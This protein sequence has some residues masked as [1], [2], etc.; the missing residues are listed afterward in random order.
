[1]LAL[2]KI[3][4]IIRGVGL[5]LA[6]ILIFALAL[7]LYFMF[8]DLSSG[9]F[10][11]VILENKINCSYSDHVG[12]LFIPIRV[13]YNGSRTIQNLQVVA[14]LNISGNVMEYETLPVTLIGSSY[15]IVMLKLTLDNKTA[16][17][18]LK[19]NVTMQMGIKFLYD[20]IFSI[21]T[22]FEFEG[23]KFRPE[24]YLKYEISETPAP[25][26]KYV[27]FGGIV[28][29]PLPIPL[30]GNITIVIHNGEVHVLKEIHVRLKPCSPN[31]VATNFTFKSK[32]LERGLTYTVF[33]NTEEGI[34][35]K[36]GKGS[37]RG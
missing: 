34:S 33:F 16:L 23:L 37:I 13:Y 2:R 12:T 17:K 21:K 26:Y 6:L 9:N 4:D 14:A 10:G 22:F 19:E 25:E 35:I 24:A 36:L 15:K 27:L 31:M 8:N 7:E 3:A 18:I 32:D 28:I 30:E 1:M 20:G 29:N 5:S 11:L